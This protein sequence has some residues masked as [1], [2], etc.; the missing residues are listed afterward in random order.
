[1]DKVDVML[2]PLRAILMQVGQFMP[3]L[4]L[5]IVILVA[6]WL[7]AKAIRLAVVKG[8]HRINFQVLTQRSGMDGFLQQGGTSADTSRILGRLVYWLVILAALVLA[9][10]SVGLAYVAELLGRAALLVARAVLAVIILVF[11]CYFAYFVDTSITAYGKKVK[12]ADAGLIGHMA[13][14]A[15]I[16]FISLIALDYLN[17]GGDLIRQSFLIV[18]AGVMLAL[19]L[20]FGLGGRELAPPS[21]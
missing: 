21:Q 10:N 7:V 3:K 20:A 19:G 5:V 17:I 11:G 1:M 12:L 13:R 16:A 18:L 14:M 4:L 9:A 2:E 8:L 6:G 15:V